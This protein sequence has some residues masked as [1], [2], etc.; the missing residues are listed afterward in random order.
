[1]DRGLKPIW[2]CR[3][4][5][6]DEA[7]ELE[8]Y[9]Q[10]QLEDD[11]ARIFDESIYSDLELS[12]G[13]QKLLTHTCLLKARTN[14][15]YN[16]LQTILHVNVNQRIF[17]EIYSF[18]SDVYTECN[19]K[20][21]E[22]EILQYLKEN[23]Q[24]E[25]KDAY[26]LS[27]DDLP[28]ENE[29]FLTPKC[30][31]P[32]PEQELKGNPLSPNTE[33]TKEYY[34]LVPIDGHTFDQ[35]IGEQDALSNAFQS[36]INAQAKE[37]IKQQL[38]PRNKPTSL[39]LTSS[40][41]TK[42]IQHSNS[43]DTFDSNRF[44]DIYYQSENVVKK[45]LDETFSL[46][47]CSIPTDELVDN[48][49]NDLKTL[50]NGE[51]VVDKTIEPSYTPDSLITD[52]P[53]SS[54]DY[55][56]ATY[57]CPPGIYSSICQP[58]NNIGDSFTKMDSTFTP[59]DS[60]VENG[61][62]ESQSSHRDITLTDL[63]L[64]ESAIQDSSSDDLKQMLSSSNPTDDNNV[65]KYK[66]ASGQS[67]KGSLSS[68]STETSSGQVAYR[69][70]EERSSV[71][72]MDLQ[73]S[74]EEKQRQNEEIVNLESSS[75]S[76]E[77]GSWESIF[78]PK[79]GEKAICEQ[80]ISEERQSNNQNT[81]TKITDFME[82]NSQSLVQKIQVQS[83]SCFIDAA[84]LQ[85][86]DETI[87]IEE[88]LKYYDNYK[89]R[90]IEK[91]DSLLPV[92]SE[93]PS[94]SQIET[95]KNGLCD[96]T[97]DYT[98][99][100]PK[101]DS[102]EI[103]EMKS[104]EE[105]HKNTSSLTNDFKQHFDASNDFGKTSD[106]PHNSINVSHPLQE[107]KATNDEKINN[108]ENNSTIDNIP[109]A[110]EK[111][112]HTF[113]IDFSSLPD[114]NPTE[115]TK[116][117]ET[118]SEKKNMFSM[119][120]DLGE[121]SKLKKIPARLSS[122]FPPR[123]NTKEKSLIE[124]TSTASFE[125]C[126]MLC[127]DTSLTISEIV[128]IHNQME[129]EKQTAFVQKS[130]PSAEANYNP[131]EMA[132]E[133][134]VKEVKN[135]QDHSDLFV[136][137]SDLDKPPMKTDFTR[138]LQRKSEGL[139]VR[140]TRSI[141]E[142][143]WRVSHT[144]TYRSTEIVSS[145]H[146]ENALSLNRL[147]P[148][149]KD[150]LISRSMPGSQGPLN[151]SNNAV[152]C[153][154]WEDELTPYAT[155]EQTTVAVTTV[156]ETCT[157]ISAEELGKLYEL[158]A[159]CQSPL[160]QDL[161]RMFIEEIAPDV[162]V[163]CS[164]RRIKAHKCI[165]ISRC[166]YFAGILS[167]SRI[168]ATG[169]VIVMPPFS[170][171]VFLFVLCYIYSGISVIPSTMNI[172]ELVTLSDMLRLEGLKEVI[173]L[174]LK[175]KYC[176]HFH[177]PCEVC[178]AGILE[179]FHLSSMYSLDDLYH[180]CL[181][182][183]TRFFPL[184]WPTKAFSSMNDY[185]VEKCVRAL[186][187]H[188]SIETFHGIVFGLGVTMAALQS[189]KWTKN[190][191]RHCYRVME[192]AIR[193]AANNLEILMRELAPL[194][195][196]AHSSAKRSLEK[197][198]KSAIE[199]APGEELC[200][201]YVLL[202]DLI[203]KQGDSGALY[204]QRFEPRT[205]LYVY[206]N[207]WQHCC[208]IALAYASPRLTRTQ[209]YKDLPYE[210]KRKLRLLSP[211]EALSPIGPVRNRDIYSNPRSVRPQLAI[212]QSTA[213]SKL[214]A[215]KT[216]ETKKSPTTSTSAV[217]T[218]KAQEQRTKFNILKKK[219]T[220]ERDNNIRG[221][222]PRQNLSPKRR[223]RSMEKNAKTDKKVP[224]Q[225]AAAQNNSS[226]NSSP[227]DSSKG[228]WSS[229]SNVAGT[230]RPKTADPA[231]EPANDNNMYAT[232]TKSSRTKKEP[233]ERT[234]PQTKLPTY[235]YSS[236]SNRH[237]DGSENMPSTS[238]ARALPAASS[239]NT[240]QQ[241]HDEPAKKTSGLIKPRPNNQLMKEKSGSLKIHH[242]ETR[243]FCTS[244]LRGSSAQ[245]HREMAGPSSRLV[246]FTVSVPKCEHHV[247][248]S[249]KAVALY[250]RPS[251]TKTQ[252]VHKVSGSLTKATKSSQAKA[253]TKVTNDGNGTAKVSKQPVKANNR[254]AVP[255]TERPLKNRSRTW[256]KDEPKDDSDDQHAFHDD[257]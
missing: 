82:N 176:H 32:F 159:S 144:S 173:M 131:D 129:S 237:H 170:Q 253:V 5:A 60:G 254:Q 203:E 45:T 199:R 148:H 95:G 231:P 151:Y 222:V 164:G 35:E 143:N 108:D 74:K 133:S 168:E 23:L 183:I 187:E 76:S 197:C 110:Q 117:V 84:S 202:G 193:Y 31:S 97:D 40:H 30:L 160:G 200:R 172:V 36:M 140:M 165:L 247:N 103:V 149:L 142:N 251:A 198:M 109:V 113:Y 78:P 225:G 43:C 13:K 192:T 191:E 28:D 38:S 71:R 58:L 47:K 51:S 59:S 122:L 249:D 132:S 88:N 195:A 18:V 136:K 232:Y 130:E 46:K 246:P 7:S 118:Q 155:N 127:K 73:S 2:A 219:L 177:S 171:E 86:E 121:K 66:Y 250:N 96:G 238:T 178:I 72:A 126:E 174:Y 80:F 152:A 48:L 145:F 161:L 104:L 239:S 50:S 157:S 256:S 227:N 26:Y 55:L 101:A 229:R 119:F 79:I 56:S 112:S 255:R 54:S 42:T 242:S 52:E 19:I 212:P 235:K 138:I 100:Q 53:S 245:M 167:G 215:N 154:D 141:P 83:G 234:L 243:I 99:P 16:T 179:S 4:S 92:L 81:V 115:D 175:T 10:K 11:V 24:F 70:T 188:I 114:S 29:I 244:P 226:G 150:Q 105:N 208:E 241:K 90:D 37:T 85:D 214:N 6:S 209:A 61:L 206:G 223:S 182:W 189:R 186:L 166:Q 169:N 57:T 14:T 162:I 156:T 17:D 196:D 107:K 252:T 123:K 134:V 15:F 163:E 87:G 106:T 204:E 68:T 64:T 147:F 248:R 139:D 135:V 128:A 9:L 194:S 210:V 89:K 236:I 27:K 111:S 75:V 218:T 33:L 205:I 22:A 230:S 181:K 116:T 62:L 125:S 233:G 1:M 102:N 220:E 213:L 44:E 180:K 190:L 25:K 49:N 207:Y 39:A 153:S 69:Q 20:H 3:T 146:S 137:L 185:L 184:V 12:C 120:I 221:A 21:Q 67:D 98:K 158:M 211:Q 8:Y 94:S 91:S 240:A 124:Q 216:V 34:A 201:T 77:T 41:T 257:H 228:K 224:S 65:S 93:T 217:R 63:S